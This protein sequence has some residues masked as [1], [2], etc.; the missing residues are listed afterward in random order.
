MKKICAIA[1]SLLAAGTVSASHL[2][3]VNSAGTF[4]DISG[5]GTALN[6]GDDTDA[7]IAGVTV[8]NG[9]FL[10]G[11]G[12]VRVNNNGGLAW[13]QSTGTLSF[14]NAS[15]IGSSPMFSAGQAL[16]VFWDD[17]DSESGNVYWRQQ[18]V[19]G[20]NTLIVQ[21]H[22]RPHFAGP[23]NDHLTVQV[24]IYNGATGGASDPYARMFYQDVLW[25]DGA[26]NRYD[27]GSSAT[28]GYQHGATSA[29]NVQWSFN[30]ASVTNGQVLAL[31][32]VPAPGAIALLGL[33]GVLGSR[34]RR[35]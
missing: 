30:T 4:V 31:Q 8:S 7:T 33:A 1:A 35:A 17:L 15:L 12:N 22:D 10:A 27:N 32:N 5:T 29:E 16:A 19:G 18:V 26:G 24:Q 25:N 13:N 2:T 20:V 14:T 34:R 3:I 21:W 11:S 23:S 28:I 6:L 9:L